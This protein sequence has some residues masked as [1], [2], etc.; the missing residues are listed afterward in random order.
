MILHCA[1][2]L[3]MKNSRVSRL[4][5]HKA[6][7]SAKSVKSNLP[8]I[9]YLSFS[10]GVFAVSRSHNFAKKYVS[11][12]IR[13]MV[14]IACILIPL[15]FYPSYINVGQATQTLFSILTFSNDHTIV[16]VFRLSNLF[17]EWI[18]C[19]ICCYWAPFS[20][21]VSVCFVGILFAMVFFCGE[22]IVP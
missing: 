6:K 5:C 3:H 2:V 10:F 14:Y 17:V 12:Y 16:C 8:Y 13:Y 4:I 7:S 9:D 20:V 19:G 18:S 1:V 15:P 21:C 22:N 11:G